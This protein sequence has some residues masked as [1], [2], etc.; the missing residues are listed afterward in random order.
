MTRA[1]SEI[2]HPPEQG[3]HTP[4]AP[5]TPPASPPLPPPAR[6]SVWTRKQ[7]LVRLLWTTLARAVWVIAPPL[8]APLL[9]AFGA[10]VGRGCTLPR[11]TEITIPWNIVLHDGVR[12]APGTIL[13]S[14][15]TI[16]VGPGTVLDQRVHICAG[17]H[18]MRDSTFPLLRPP[19]T[20]GARCFLGFDA[21]IGPGVTLGDDVR[22]HPRASV[23]RDAPIGATLIGN[24]A[25]IVE[26]PTPSEPDP[27][28]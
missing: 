13:Y 20:I 2:Q 18:D 9:R 17:T 12:L 25:K 7:N 22:V 15:G 14:L 19:I 21:Y 4:G 24:P 1:T 28:A 10:R 16:T 27:D 3:A 5:T 6:R 8:R 26:A 11:D 23:Y